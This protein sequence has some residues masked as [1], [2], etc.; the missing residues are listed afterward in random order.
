MNSHTNKQPPKADSV[1]LHSE[2]GIELDT[3]FGPHSM[4]AQ[5]HAGLTLSLEIS[6]YALFASFISVMT[7]LPN[8]AV[9]IQA[10]FPSTVLTDPIG[11]VLWIK[12]ALFIA[13]LVPLF[14][15][16][17]LSSKRL[18]GRLFARRRFRL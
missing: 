14:W 13:S 9:N 2:H 5:T 1:F 7:L 17:H 10:M 15:A 3:L 6:L 4:D 12:M 8:Q 11:F 18:K 16:L